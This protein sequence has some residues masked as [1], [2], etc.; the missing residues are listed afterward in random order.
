MNEE[1]GLP[2]EEQPSKS[3]IKREMLALQQLGERLVGL[4]PQLWEQFDFGPAMRDALEE[5]RR[6]KS[7]NAM[8]RHVRRLGKLLQQENSELV[9]QLFARMDHEQLRDTQHFH[10]LER[11]RDRL[12]DEG[13]RVLGELLDECPNADRQQLRQLVRQARKER[14]EQKPP[15]M[16][17]KLFRYLRELDWI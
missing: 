14:S 9:E 1:H 10:R 15:T 7:H 16:Q 13:D 11:W 12:L 2:E 5:S 6:I 8:R 17:R 3:A 4:K